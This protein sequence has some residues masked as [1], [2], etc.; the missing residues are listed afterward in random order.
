MGT[1]LA[2]YVTQSG[3]RA[4]G[5]KQCGLSSAVQSVVPSH[6]QQQATDAVVTSNFLVFVV[7][8]AT[9]V[10]VVDPF[11]RYAYWNDDQLRVENG[12]VR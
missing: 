7:V 3:C 4:V 2:C 6:A 11:F 1:T 12:W 8:M 5:S 9:S 10:L